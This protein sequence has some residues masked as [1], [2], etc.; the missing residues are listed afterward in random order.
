MKNTKELHSILGCLFYLNQT[1]S[2][3]EKVKNIIDYAFE[4]VYGESTNMMLLCSTGYSREDALP[5]IEQILKQDTK[6]YDYMKL[7]EN[8]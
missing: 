6:F 3:D 7:K 8:N 1:G 2:R 4:R 5:E